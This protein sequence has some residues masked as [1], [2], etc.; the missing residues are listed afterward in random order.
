MSQGGQVLDKDVAKIQ[1]I[2]RDENLLYVVTY[3]D[4]SEREIETDNIY[5]VLKVGTVKPNR[6]K[7]MLSTRGFPTTYDLAA[8]FD[9][10]VKIL[11]EAGV[12]TSKIT[13]YLPDGNGWQK[14]HGPMPVE[15]AKKICEEYWEKRT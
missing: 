14:L 8:R 3:W 7:G 6:P 4:G 13:F 10:S 15:E 11:R 2:E 9:E 1:I 5:T 12:D